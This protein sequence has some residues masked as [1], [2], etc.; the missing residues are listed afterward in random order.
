MRIIKK[1][2]F[3]TKGCHRLSRNGQK[4][5]GLFYFSTKRLTAFEDQKT[6]SRADRRQ[7]ISQAQ[8]MQHAASNMASAR[9]NGLT[10]KRITKTRNLNL[11]HY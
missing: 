11:S 9:V 10:H 5:I 6:R 1:M 7:A 2:F 3:N 4:S 8:N